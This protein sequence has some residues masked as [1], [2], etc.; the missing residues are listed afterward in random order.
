MR[1]RGA[2]LSLAPRRQTVDREAPH[3]QG[4]R[5][6]VKTERVSKW[7][8]AACTQIALGG[9]SHEDSACHRR[10]SVH[11]RI[12]RPQQGQPRKANKSSPC[13]HVR[14][15]GDL[16]SSASCPHKA[17][18]AGPHSQP[19]AAHKLPY[20][21]PLTI[22]EVNEED[23][24][25]GGCLLPVVSETTGR[26]SSRWSSSRLCELEKLLSVDSDTSR[27]SDSGGAA[28]N[29]AADNTAESCIVMRTPFSDEPP[30]CQDRELSPVRG[31]GHMPCSNSLGVK[32]VPP[33]MRKVW[34]P[35]AL[36][37]LHRKTL[38]H[39]ERN[40]PVVGS[41]GGGCGLERSLTC[42]PGQQTVD[43]AAVMEA[44]VHSAKLHMSPSSAELASRCL[45]SVT[46]T[47]P[48]A[49][50]RQG[51]GNMAYS[52]MGSCPGPVPYPLALVHCGDM[53]TG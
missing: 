45:P 12:P 38:P 46:L 4:S 9:Y 52:R 21:R 24:G 49:S 8:E 29:Q 41:P 6:A 36:P 39:S 42:Y 7:V 37:L 35:A 26:S 53:A 3:D 10:S 34:T 28:A 25:G 15:S 27:T 16:R 32:D 40:S 13:R 47:M 22:P 19:P 14:P 43:M 11:A 33:G 51:Q 5:R 31:C 48:P 44:A 20:A 30:P 50:V 1:R 17:H 2:H 23:D 18:A